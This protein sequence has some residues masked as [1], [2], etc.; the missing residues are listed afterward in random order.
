MK[1]N[2]TRRGKTSWRLKFD[3]GRDPVTGRRITK[4][5]TLRGT[6]A[7]AQEQVN[8]ILAEVAA[9]THIEPSA[10]T[11]GE[12]VRARVSQW[13]ASGTI[14]ARTVER[15]RQLVENQVV[16]FLGN[17][18]LQRLRPLDI[19]GWHT[20]LRNTGRVRGSGGVA[21]RSIGSAHRLLSKALKDAVKNGLISR[22]VAT[23]EPP[24][25]VTEA[26]MVIVR[27]VSAFMEKLQGSAL[28]APALL[29][30]LCG[31]RL[32]EVLAVRWNRINFESKVIQIREALEQTAR[33]ARLKPPKSRAGIRD[34]TMPDSVVDALR[35]YRRSQ[36][37][38]RMQLGAGRLPEDALLF[39]DLNGRP[40]SLYVASAAWRAFAKKIG[41]PGLTFHCLRH[42]HASQLIHEGVD[43]VTISKRL[44][45]AKPD[46][47]LRVYAHLFQKDD[48]KA[49][50]AINAALRR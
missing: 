3:T 9:G 35:D 7:Q 33:A 47:T 10:I 22:N 41:M 21:A 11:V 14:S 16:P 50:A 4:F 24:P 29:G 25:K 19:E 20:T 32:G 36:L 17:K 18:E 28:Q 2:L 1:G 15:Y 6:K 12:F 27:D 26:E 23:L 5:V 46:I 40:R 38:L 42:S 34:I 45:H 48:S 49:A 13:E 8:R 43:I 31:M 39:A 44:G 30:L 37:E